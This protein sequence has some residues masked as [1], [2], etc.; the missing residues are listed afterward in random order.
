LVKFSKIIKGGGGTC[1]YPY[2][3]Y[4]SMERVNAG[5]PP[6]AA[7]SPRRGGGPSP[8]RGVSPP[9]GGGY[10]R[11]LR[12]AQHPG[13]GWRL[14]YI[15]GRGGMYLHLP[16]RGGHIFPPPPPSSYIYIN[17]GF[18]RLLKASYI[19]IRSLKKP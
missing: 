3:I 17:R 6:P 4:P 12:R 15:Y 14:I 5:T 1:I 16:F 7:Q 8:P 9:V 11:R 18:L 2:C 13:G 10:T 19:Y